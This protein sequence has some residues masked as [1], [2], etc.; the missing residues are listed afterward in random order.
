MDW[1]LGISTLL[2][3][4]NLGWSKGVWWAWIL[5]FF[6]AAAWQAYVTHTEQWG[7]VTLNIATMVVGLVSGLRSYRKSH[8][9]YERALKE[10]NEHAWVAKTRLEE[11][12]EKFVQRLR[13]QMDVW[14]VSYKAY[15]EL[16]IDFLLA[17][18]EDK[19]DC[20]RISMEYHGT[21]YHVDV[22]LTSIDDSPDIRTFADKIFDQ[23][24]G[25][26]GGFS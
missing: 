8:P 19:E 18:I 17:G 7:F 4:A 20:M 22:T 23:L 3:N 1:I 25:A 14:N 9:T 2:I 11:S 5:L 15:A 16:H 13:L 21:T 24:S 10:H 12:M 26:A 6:N